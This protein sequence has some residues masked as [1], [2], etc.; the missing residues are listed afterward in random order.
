VVKEKALTDSP[1]FILFFFV[2]IHTL[3]CGGNVKYIF[4]VSNI[5]E[6]FLPEAVYF[7]SSV[8]RLQVKRREGKN[9]IKYIFVGKK[10]KA[11][12][13]EFVLC[14]N[15]VCAKFRER[16]KVLIKTFP[17]KSSLKK[18]GLY[19]WEIFSRRLRTR[20]M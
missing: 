18:C 16:K 10:K 1:F 12:R 19:E 5:K 8:V 3:L 20:I 13:N 7:L 6:L 4:C 9:K 2:F 17:N 11:L 15:D 14:G